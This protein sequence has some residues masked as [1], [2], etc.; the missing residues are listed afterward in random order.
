MRSSTISS[1]SLMPANPRR[2]RRS[3]QN[4]S[5]SCSVAPSCFIHLVR[6]RPAWEREVQ[7]KKSSEKLL[8]RARKNLPSSGA[9]GQLLTSQT[10]TGPFF[11]NSFQLSKSL[12]NSERVP[13]NTSVRLV[14]EYVSR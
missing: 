1:K 14:N 2:R 3:R 7:I 13:D 8:S 4:S 10:S 5:S 12:C 6:A 9:E 11:L